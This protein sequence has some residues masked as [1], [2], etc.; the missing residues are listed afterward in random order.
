[1]SPRSHTSP[2][3]SPSRRN[4]RSSSLRRLGSARALNT[5]SMRRQLC[6]HLV[7]CQAVRQAR[8]M[9]MLGT[10]P[11]ELKTM[12]PIPTELVFLSARRTPFGTY[13]GSLKDLS[14]TEL[15]VHAA[16]A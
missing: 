15:G 16:K 7:T 11:T 3:V 8:E 14:A 1:M 2:S 6:D 9:V 13:G 4:S 12:K 5:S 10:R